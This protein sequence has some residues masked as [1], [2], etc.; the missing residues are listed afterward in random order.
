MQKTIFIFS[1]LSLNLHSA[2]RS[3]RLSFM[4]SAWANVLLWQTQSSAYLSKDMWGYFYKTSIYQRYSARTGLLKLDIWLNP[5][6]LP[7]VSL[8]SVHH[9]S[10]KRRSTSVLYREVSILSW[11]ASPPLS[12]VS[13]G[14]LYQ[15]TWIYP[16]LKP[17][18]TSNTV[19][20]P[21]LWHHALKGRNIK[22]YQMKLKPNSY[23]LE[24]ELIK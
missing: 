1:S 23:L 18:Y 10:D 3:P 6:V 17:M 7:C 21:W 19:F 12:L 14:R 8:Q 20:L 2:K 13:H 15:R 16:Y 4:Y 11:Y 5:V 9:F 24:A 22:Y